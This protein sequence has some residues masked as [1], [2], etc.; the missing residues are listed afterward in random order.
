VGKS[1]KR[2][3]ADL[4]EADQ[5]AL[6]S[7]LDQDILDQM[8]REEWWWVSRPEQ[9]PPDGDWSVHCYLA[10]R[11]CGKTRSGAEWLVDRTI[12]HPYDSSGFPTERLVMAHNLSDTRT[13]CIEG[14]SGI[15]RVLNRR[16]FQEVSNYYTGDGVNKYH[17][18][19][20]PKPHI[21]LLETGA[22]IHFTGANADA[23]RG[24]NLADV[25][26]DEPCKWL[27]AADV[28]WKE[29]IRP[30]LRADI[31][32]DKPRAFVT[33]TPKPIP[34]LHEWLAKTDGTISWARGSTFDNADNLSEDFIAEV[35]EMYGDSAL[36]RQELYGEM[37][38]ALEGALFTW[39]SINN[40]RVE[41]GPQRVA[42]RCVGVDPGLTGGED[43]DEM[44]V[45]VVSRDSEDHMY[46]LADETTR[47]AGRDAA[48][49][50]WRTF[51][52]YQCDTLVYENNLGKAWMHEV[53]TDV[54]KELQRAGVFPTEITT[55]PLV[56]VFSNYGKK[57]RAEPV[58]IRYAQGR[59]HHIGTFDL[60][61]KQMLTFDPVTSKTSPD[62]LD[63]L[64][65]ACR[66]LIDGEK[67]RSRIIS[68]VKY[69]IASL[70]AGTYRR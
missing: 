58:A 14:A 43:G 67:R 4:S 32:G 3:F 49:H 69:R 50:A 16:G 24:Y 53:L 15:L 11:G 64:V 51:E 56:P 36:G 1:L 35:R 39:I 29:G 40:H 47:A 68:P 31:P 70:D 55:P 63:A 66:H 42:H 45:V 17:Y 9:N 23:A 41:I 61:E 19:K 59:V 60:L 13:V 10:G 57:L 2:V 7:T 26:M 20:S 44:G 54:F 33:T 25:W 37:V 62:R 22:K 52:R 5:H 38:D 27:E 8:A 21:T 46:V 12:T 18:T 6:L 28:V 65:H 30:A 34:L 48:L